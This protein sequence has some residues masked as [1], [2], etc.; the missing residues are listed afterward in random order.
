[1][2][3]GRNVMNSCF[4]A[5]L[6][7]RRSACRSA[8]R[9][10]CVLLVIPFHPACR[11]HKLLTTGKERVAV[12]TNLKLQVTYCRPRFECVTA[13]TRHNRFLILRVNSSLHEPGSFLCQE[14]LSFFVNLIYAFRTTE[15][16]LASGVRFHDSA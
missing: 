7:V 10:L 13:D 6:Q 1:M 5:V 14:L 12:G 8:R 9:F 11:V 2:G 15:T 4:E 3:F 16:T